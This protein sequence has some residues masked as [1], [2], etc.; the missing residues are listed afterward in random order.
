MLTLQAA[1]LSCPLGAAETP[2]R[3]HHSSQHQAK[4]AEGSQYAYAHARPL[5]LGAPWNNIGLVDLLHQLRCRA[6]LVVGGWHPAPLLHLIHMRVFRAC[7]H[8]GRGRAAIQHT[9]QSCRSFK[10]RTF[11]NSLNG[12]W[13]AAG[14][15]V[16]LRD[17]FL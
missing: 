14:Y 17:L 12:P 3:Q 7:R 16:V 5:K 11:S 8:V 13:H 9:H 1:C 6:G 15:M 10:K 4:P 2:L